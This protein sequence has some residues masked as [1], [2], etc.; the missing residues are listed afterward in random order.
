MKKRCREQFT[1][2][3]GLILFL[4][5]P[6]AT[7]KDSTNEWVQIRHFENIRLTR[8]ERW[9]LDLNADGI[10]T[11]HLTSA[12]EKGFFHPTR[13]SDCASSG[14]LYLYQFKPEMI[15]QFKIALNAMVKEQ[16]PLQKPNK[17]RPQPPT[18]TFTVESGSDQSGI[19]SISIIDLHLP[20]TKTFMNV[21]DQMHHELMN[22]R[23]QVLRMKVS[24]N[25]SKNISVELKNEGMQT[26]AIP[27][28]DH[29]SEAFQVILKNGNFAKVEFVQKPKGEFIEIKSGKSVIFNLTIKSSENQ[30][31]IRE[32]RFQNRTI[33]HHL[34]R[35][36]RA[37]ELSLC[38]L[39][40]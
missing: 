17:D 27:I 15:Q 33:L 10:A 18:Q 13:I 1:L 28:P 9:S 36:K 11:L 38:T 34:P 16:D 20:K 5:I 14:G 25:S 7:A 8:S 29:A 21:L 19:H 26:I 3:L 37:L 30:S 22:S 40:L 32:I 6:S 24:K 39:T 31:F 12:H 4:S 35:N 2:L 23:V